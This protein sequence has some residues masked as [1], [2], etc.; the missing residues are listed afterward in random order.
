MCLTLSMVCAIGIIVQ[1]LALFQ[2]QY[3]KFNLKLNVGSMETVYIFVGYTWPLSQHNQFS[4]EYFTYDGCG[5]DE[6][7]IYTSIRH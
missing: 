5:F 1:L 3:V 7:H 2:L 4:F 6:K